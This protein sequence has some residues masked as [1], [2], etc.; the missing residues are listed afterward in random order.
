MP[1]EDEEDQEDEE[2]EEDERESKPT[3][4]QQVYDMR[5]LVC[6]LLIPALSGRAVDILQG[7]DQTDCYELWQRLLAEFRGI[8]R[9][10]ISQT[11]A[12]VWKTRGD[13]AKPLSDLISNLNRQF[14]NLSFYKEAMSENAKIGALIN[15]LPLP[16]FETALPQLYSYQNSDSDYKTVS[17]YLINFDTSNNAGAYSKKREPAQAARVYQA[18]TPQSQTSKQN[19]K[20]GKCFNCDKAGHWTNECR[21]PCKLPGHSKHAR[22]D[23]KKQNPKS[24]GANSNTNTAFKAKKTEADQQDTG[25]SSYS[26]MMTSAFVANTTNPTLAWDTCCS[27]HLVCPEQVLNNKRKLETVTIEAADGKRITLTEGG[28]YYAMLVD[29]SGRINKIKFSN[30]YINPGLKGI[31][32]ISQGILDKK[33]FHSVISGGKFSISTN[34]ITG[35][36]EKGVIATGERLPGANIFVFFTHSTQIVA[37]NKITQTKEQSKLATTTQAVLFVAP[38]NG[39]HGSQTLNEQT[40]HQRL[41]HASKQMA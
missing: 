10:S 17:S 20:P 40:W 5:R 41:G 26:W 33:G 36:F 22:K 27:Y 30:A 18:T 29:G 24:K 1:Q 15:A 7:T 34:P 13:P 25:D 32:L 4:V 35:E 23:C 3:S 6:G 11:H 38:K 8:G 21:R 31:N 12:A 2:I 39:V 9:A 28:D 14:D 19:S 37:Q 16:K